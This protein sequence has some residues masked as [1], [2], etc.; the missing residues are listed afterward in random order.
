M[1]NEVQMT[2]WVESELRAEFFDAASQD[3]L[4]AEQV[5]R[6]FMKTYVNQARVRGLSTVDDAVAPAESRRRERAANFAR[7]SVGLEG[8]TPHRADE[9]L[10]RR[11]V[12]GEISIEDAIKAINE[13]ASAR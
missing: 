1:S 7:A 5:L 4:S 3:E 8:F 10:S 2:F 12:A 11:Y 6:E 9:E 13:S